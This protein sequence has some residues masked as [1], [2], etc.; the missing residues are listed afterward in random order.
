MSIFWQTILKR[1]GRAFL[2]GFVSSAVL[3][4]PLTIT[5][6]QDLGGYVNSLA[7]AGVVGGITGLL[8]ALDK[9]MRWE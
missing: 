3:I 4:T 9:A 6:W 1:F 5:S 7:L 2:A 8:Q